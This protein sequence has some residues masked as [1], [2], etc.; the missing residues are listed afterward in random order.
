MFE[1]VFA[2]AVFTIALGKGTE[3]VVHAWKG[4][5][6][7]GHAKRM[8]RIREREAKAARRDLARTEGFRGWARLIWVDSWNA[9]AERHRERW[10]D[11]AEK[12]AEYARR[13]WAWWDGVQDDA[14]NRWEQRRRERVRQAHARAAEEAARAW[15]EA[16]KA[17]AAAATAARQA[18]DARRHATAGGFAWAS[19]DGTTEYIR[20][21][22]DG[23][24]PDGETYRNGEDGFFH[25]DKDGSTWI[26]HPG[27]G[28][29][30]TGR[31][32]SAEQRVR[33][34]EERARRAQET[35]RTA[36]EFAKR[37]QER[38]D[39]AERE[40]SSRPTTTVTPDPTP[41]PD[42]DEEDIVD[43]EIVYP[44]LEAAPAAGPDTTTH[45]APKPDLQSVATGGTTTEEDTQMSTTTTEAIGL[46]GALA[47]AQGV[48]NTSAANVSTTETVVAAM[49]NGKVGASVVG[50]TQ[51][52]MEAMDAVK[53]IAEQLKADL[54]RM[55]G[56]QEQYDANP[57]AGDKEYVATN[58]GR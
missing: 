55:K 38:A 1:L 52:L 56:V 15:E 10:P 57:D 5:V 58:A 51:Q 39:R 36:A 20:P 35:A 50:R 28:P 3:A 6:P 24:M 29:Y 54:E 16:A 49:T 14:E 19:D 26:R 42:Q 27:P 13:R 47:F 44:E 30:A 18:E 53:T 33:E 7:P 2:W 17:R 45:P 41:A 48:V 32:R 46:D 25:R 8:A 21:N 12:K 22:A 9:A 43:A 34:A 11:K 23:T 40:A 37:A 4:T 31:E